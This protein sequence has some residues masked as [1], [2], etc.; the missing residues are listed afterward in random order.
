MSAP[1]P[2]GARFF[3]AMVVTACIGAAMWA[4][5]IGAVGAAWGW[6]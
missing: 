4:I 6:W 5:V 2:E 1:T 3:R